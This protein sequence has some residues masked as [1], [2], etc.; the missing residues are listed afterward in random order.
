M[1]D[2]PRIRELLARL[3]AAARVP[4][5]APRRCRWFVDSGLVVPDRL[6]ALFAEVESELVKYPPVDPDTL[7]RR[8]RDLA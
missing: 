8:L 1:A 6:R 2:E 4:W 5:A 3:G 7:R